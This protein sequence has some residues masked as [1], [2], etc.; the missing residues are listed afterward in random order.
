MTDATTED[1]AEMVDSDVSALV[2]RLREARDAVDDA[3]SAIADHGEDEVNRAVNAHRRAT[4]LL[5]DYEDSATG[6][7]DF[8]AYVQFQEEFIGLVESLPEDAP[9]RGAFE[10]AAERMDRRRLRERDFAGAREDLEPAA[11]LRAL[12]GRRESARDELAAARRDAT[13]RLE[14]LDEAAAE[15]A[16][17]VALGDAVGRGPTDGQT[18]SGD[19]DVDALVERLRDP[20]ETYAESVREEF[21]RWKAES[22]ARD[23]LELPARATAFPLVE[24]RSPPRDVLDYVRERRGGEHP[25]PKLLEYTGYSG[26]KLDH[27]VDDAAALQTSVAVHRT[28]L[29]RLDADPLVVSWPPPQAEVLRRRADE[30]IS[31]LDRFASEDTIA[32]LR[33]VRDATR[34]DDYA[35]LRT[36]A[37]ARNE[38][39]EEQ[40]SRLRSGAVETELEAVRDARARLA[41]ALEET[42]EEGGDA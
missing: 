37:R 27:Y 14:E 3:E 11:R 19:A 8:Q 33:R 13:L 4:T 2:R 5:D 26:S 23:V 28:Y 39:T 38:V 41:A 31:L 35:R 34:R 16:D 24:Y 10:D 9:V 17:L 36:V 21:R 12:L 32:T 29:E 6:T 22:P 30:I 15:L 42:D 1:T 20:V 18:Q 40:L 7:G 25:I